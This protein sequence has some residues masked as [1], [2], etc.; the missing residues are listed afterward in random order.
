MKKYRN[1]DIVV[2][3]DDL[4]DRIRGSVTAEALADIIEGV[5]NSIFREALVLISKKNRNRIIGLVQCA[6][7][8]LY[9]NYYK[10]GKYIESYN[11]KAREGS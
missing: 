10:M 3:G 6:H 11:M 7:G 1:V 2:Y 8:V 5:D 4:K 9:A